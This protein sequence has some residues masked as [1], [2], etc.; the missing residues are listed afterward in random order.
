MTFIGSFRLNF[1]CLRWALDDD[2]WH[3][4]QIRETKAMMGM[5]MG[6]Q[7]AMQGSEATD[8]ATPAIKSEDKHATCPNFFAQ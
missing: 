6:M 7:A 3:V 4:L 1:V 5:M 2:M 8:D